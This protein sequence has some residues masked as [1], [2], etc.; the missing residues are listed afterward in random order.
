[1]DLAERHKLKQKED[2]DEEAMP[3]EDMFCSLPPTAGWGMGIDRLI[4]LL[5]YYSSRESPVQLYFLAQSRL[6]LHNL[7]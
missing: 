7:Y 6:S 5:K 2:Q 3:D 4:M 1:M